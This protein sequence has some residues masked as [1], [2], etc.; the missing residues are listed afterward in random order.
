[1]HVHVPVEGARIC[2]GSATRGWWLILLLTIAQTIARIV[3]SIKKI[4]LWKIT[5]VRIYRRDR[6]TT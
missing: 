1:M 4:A 5:H 2:P 3:L 6:N